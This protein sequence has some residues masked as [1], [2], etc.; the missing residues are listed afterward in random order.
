MPGVSPFVILESVFSEPPGLNWFK[1]QMSPMLVLLSFLGCVPEQTLNGLGTAF[2]KE[3]FLS[4]SLARPVAFL[5]L[6]KPQL[7]FSLPVIA[8]GSS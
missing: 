7:E 1:I 6:G 2:D 8:V 3:Q 5:R 4:S